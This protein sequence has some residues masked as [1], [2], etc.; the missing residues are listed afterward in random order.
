MDSAHAFEEKCSQNP[1]S[2]VHL[3]VFFL[4]LKVGPEV[5]EIVV[6]KGFAMHT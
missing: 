2:E 5:G 1:D 4:K 6:G 3:I